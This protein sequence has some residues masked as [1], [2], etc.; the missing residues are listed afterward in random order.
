MVKL[1]K[2]KIMKSI[3]YRLGDLNYRLDI[4]NNKMGRQEIITMINSDYK[5]LFDQYDEVNLKYNCF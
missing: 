3:H 5:E 2:I 4:P 1:N